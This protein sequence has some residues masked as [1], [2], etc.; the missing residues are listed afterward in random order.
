MINEHVQVITKL[1][2]HEWALAHAPQNNTKF[3]AANV[4]YKSSDEN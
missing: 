1:S 3:W 2:D 4:F